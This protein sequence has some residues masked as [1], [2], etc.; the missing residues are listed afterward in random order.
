V[1]T[2]DCWRVAVQAASQAHAQLV[3]L[4]VTVTRG[5]FSVGK[6]K[7]DALGDV[8]A[9]DELDPPSPLPRGGVVVE[10]QCVRRCQD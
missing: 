1:P 5:E 7:F 3:E 8:A 2:L 6:L 9:P 4:G 10:L